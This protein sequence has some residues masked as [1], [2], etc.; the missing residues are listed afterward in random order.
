[1]GEMTEG[2]KPKERKNVKWGSE[3]PKG[4]VIPKSAMKTKMTPAESLSP[5]RSR[6]DEAQ[7]RNITNIDAN[8]DPMTAPAATPEKEQKDPF[9]DAFTIAT[10]PIAKLRP[11]VLR[12]N[13]YQKTKE[14]PEEEHEDG[15][16]D[17]NEKTFSALAAQDRA[18]RVATL[19]GSNSAPGSR[20]N[21]VEDIF[22]EDYDSPT[23]RPGRHQLP[24]RIDD[25]PLVEMDRKRLE[26]GEYRDFED[27]ETA[28]NEYKHTSSSAAHKLVR[29]HT[30][31]NH[32]NPFSDAES[33]QSGTATPAAQR[34][35]GSEWVPKPTEYRGGV[36]SSLLK[37]YNPPPGQTTSGSPSQTVTPGS[38]GYNTPSRPKAAKW[39]D[40]KNQGMQ[41]TDTLSTLVGAASALKA[42]ASPGM[43]GAGYGGRPGS[44]PVSAAE[45]RSNS[46]TRPARPGMPKRTFSSQLMDTAR[47]IGK[48][49]K[50]RVVFSM[51]KG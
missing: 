30:R 31:K 36:L 20:R 1:M 46:R 45:S 43:A 3:E 9:D 42:T 25:I 32:T 48:P 21:S 27:E 19:V 6:F 4:K 15:I 35:A 22:D 29:A 47:G 50:Y 2:V 44:R 7:L 5:N 38:S 16:E 10:S 26:Q 37:L 51:T 18:R 33:L 34:D 13:S 17:I 14:V 40:K 49:R 12:L 28:L 24:V 11:S 23:F 41:S 8:K 39:Y